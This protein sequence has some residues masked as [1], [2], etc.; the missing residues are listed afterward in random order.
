MTVDISVIIVNWNTCQL[1]V[2]CLSSI[3]QFNEDSSLEIIVV[4]NASTDGSIEHIE[5]NF[6]DIRLIRNASN[7]GFAAANNLGIAIAKGRLIL[8]QNLLHV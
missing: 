3:A 6:P 2:Q 4:D 8:R 5:E 1:L 7:Q